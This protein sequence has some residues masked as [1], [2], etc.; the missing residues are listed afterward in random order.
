MV[1]CMKYRSLGILSSLHFCLP[2]I[3][4]CWQFNGKERSSKLPE[5]KAYFRT[6]PSSE[7]AK[8]L[9]LIWNEINSVFP[10]G[11]LSLKNVLNKALGLKHLHLHQ[12]MTSLLNSVLLQ[13][14]LNSLVKKSLHMVLRA[15]I[16][17]VNL[18]SFEWGWEYQQKMVVKTD[19]LQFKYK[20][21]CK[22]LFL[23]KF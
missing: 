6:S 10:C 21:R 16:N 8:V 20:L 5:K 15:L 2:H 23:V 13:L 4:Q 7:K 12:I 19:L 14:I 17:N 18:Y 1:S 22:C 9:F 3:R 11:Q